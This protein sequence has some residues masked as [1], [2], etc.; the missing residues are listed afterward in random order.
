MNLYL[1]KHHSLGDWEFEAG[2]EYFLS[3][4][5]YLSAPKALC[6]PLNIT[7]VHN[8]YVYLKESVIKNL[9][10]GQFITGFRYHS[11]IQPINIFFR[12][13]P[14]LIH[15][16]NQNGYYIYARFQFNTW[17]ILKYVGG[18]GGIEYPGVLAVCPVDQWHQ[19]KVEFYEYVDE[20]L[21][22]IFHIELFLFYDGDWQSQGYWEDSDPTFGDSDVNRIGFSLYGHDIGSRHWADNTEILEAIK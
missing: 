8:Y 6:S 20:N 16:P 22:P 14:P 9:P 10:N 7:G 3:D 4:E 19:L 18:I 17:A 13:Q 5:Q 11:A 1:P 15:T 12:Q 21:D 2:N